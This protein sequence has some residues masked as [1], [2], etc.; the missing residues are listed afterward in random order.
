MSLREYFAGQALIG[1]MARDVAYIEGQTAAAA[2]VRV[3]DALVA[4]LRKGGVK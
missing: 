4:E 3:A 2:C 1:L